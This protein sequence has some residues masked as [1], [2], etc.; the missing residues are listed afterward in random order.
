MS[1]ATPQNAILLLGVLLL[2]SPFVAKT[3]SLWLSSIVWRRNLEQSRE[4]GTVVRLLELKHVLERDGL[5]VAS[6]VCQDLVYSV[7][8]NTTPPNKPEPAKPENHRA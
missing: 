5:N 1:F 6:R 7:I 4:I 3:V 2:A 8:Y